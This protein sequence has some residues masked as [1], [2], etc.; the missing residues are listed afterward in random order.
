MAM[1]AVDNKDN[2]VR[3]RREL[4]SSAAVGVPYHIHCNRGVVG[5]LDGFFGH[6]V[7]SNRI[8]FRPTFALDEMLG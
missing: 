1:S 7:P 3:T 5:C 2:R 4:N 6:G 8:V